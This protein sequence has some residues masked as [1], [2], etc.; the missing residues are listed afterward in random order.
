MKKIFLFFWLV[1]CFF[2]VKAQ[3][4][5]TAAESYIKEYYADF[6]TG[7][8]FDGKY[9]LLTNNY[10][11]VFSGS[12]FTLSFDSYNE[13]NTLKHKTISIDLKEVLRIEN[14]GGSI[15]EVQDIQPYGLPVSYLL[16]FVTEDEIFEINIFFDVHKDIEYSEIFKAFEVLRNWH[17]VS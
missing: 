7:Y 1:F 10:N 3:S 2:G 14:G 12:V 5:P 4:K 16:M 15:V 6:K 13:Q 8:N 17:Q 11:A 9:T